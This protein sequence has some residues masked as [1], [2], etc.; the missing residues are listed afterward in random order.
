MMFRK[1][2][3]GELYAYVPQNTENANA[4]ANATPKTPDVPPNDEYGTSVGRRSFTWKTGAWTHVAQRVKLN[5][6]GQANGE[7]EIFID[8]KSTIRVTGLKLRTSNS[9]KVRG[10]VIQTFFGGEYSFSYVVVFAAF[11]M[12]SSLGHDSTWAS[13]KKQRSYFKDFTAAI[14]Y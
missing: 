2:G 14:I 7:M 1:E 13:P 12:V 9:N 4:L 3:G 8:G 10:M 6:V 5:T 11:L